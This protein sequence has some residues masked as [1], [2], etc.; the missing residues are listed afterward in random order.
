MMSGNII[1]SL[2]EFFGYTENK[3]K[4]DQYDKLYNYLKSKEKELEKLMQEITSAKKRYDGKNGSV[5]A[6]KIPAREF[7]AKRRQKDE[8][9]S[10]TINYFSEALDNVNY[11]KNRAY[12]KWEEYK[13]KAIAEEEA[14]RVAIEAE[15]NRMQNM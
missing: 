12:Q 6:D 3:R 2:L 5:P 14:A 10:K 7:E 1:D 4:R 9:F 15:K 8:D 13:A 11:A